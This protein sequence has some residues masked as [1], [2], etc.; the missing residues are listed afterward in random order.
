MKTIKLKIIDAADIIK[1]HL[2][3][4]NTEYTLGVIPETTNIIQAT[5]DGKV[6]LFYVEEV[7]AAEG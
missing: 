4:D 2:S 1:K 5:P 3:N 7:K 6:L